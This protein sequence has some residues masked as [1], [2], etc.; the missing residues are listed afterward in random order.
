MSVINALLAL[1]PRVG[2]DAVRFVVADRGPAGYTRLVMSD[3]AFDSKKFP[4]NDRVFAQADLMAQAADI[5]KSIEGAQAS[6]YYVDAQKVQHASMSVNIP[7]EG[8]GTATPMMDVNARLASAT[9]DYLA[10]GGDV[11][12]LA[13]VGAMN[14]AMALAVVE[15]MTAKLNPAPVAPAQNQ[16]DD[17]DVPF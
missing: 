7:K 8:T 13:S 14:P 6:S 15:S 4:T 12:G 5:V 2:A 16:A 1:K 9:T 17:G 10:R 3:A 11:A